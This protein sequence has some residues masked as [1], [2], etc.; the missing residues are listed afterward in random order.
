MRKEPR[1]GSSRQSSCA[2]GAS[3][4]SRSRRL[5]A[6]QC[7]GASGDTEPAGSYSRRPQTSTW[8][9]PASHGSAL[10][11]RSSTSNSVP[12]RPPHTTFTARSP[13]PSASC[14]ARVMGRGGAI[15][16][17][18]AMLRARR[19]LSVSC[20]PVNVTPGGG[21]VRTPRPS[22]CRCSA[23]PAP[24]SAPRRSEAASACPPASAASPGSWPASLRAVGSA[25][26]RSSAA[27]AGA[28]PALAA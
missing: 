4:A 15:R 14:A 9:G 7:P 10:P 1:T 8:S 13:V 16:Q 22:G 21:S 23:R 12:W 18:A 3:P 6:T 19:R 24:S 27:H 26:S 20:R 2:S 11:L 17:P 5:R 28:A 25:P